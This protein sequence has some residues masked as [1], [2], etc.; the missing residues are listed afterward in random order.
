MYTR[1]IVWLPPHYGYIHSVIHTAF[2][3]PQGPVVEEPCHAEEVR[4]E[5][6]PQRAVRRQHEPR[7]FPPEARAVGGAS[8]AKKQDGVRILKHPLL[9]G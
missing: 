7:R 8:S 6:Q 9:M 5:R 4:V 1:V 3:Q 2:D